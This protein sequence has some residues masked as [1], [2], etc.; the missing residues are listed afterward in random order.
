[1]MPQYI[2]TIVYLVWLFAVL[3]FLYL[4][5]RR[6]AIQMERLRNAVIDASVKNADASLKAAD[7]AQKAADAASILAKRVEKSRDG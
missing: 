4:I 2:L 7:A 5:W 3:V 1:M 6:G